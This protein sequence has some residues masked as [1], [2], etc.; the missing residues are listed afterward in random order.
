LY[1][2]IDVGGYYLILVCLLS[3]A[4]WYLIGLLLDCLRRR[5]NTRRAAANGSLPKI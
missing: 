3:F 2:G 4:Q 5:L 1:G